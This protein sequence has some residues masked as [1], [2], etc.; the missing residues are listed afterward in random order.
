MFHSHRIFTA[1]IHLP[2]WRVNPAARK[3]QRASSSTHTSRD[4]FPEFISRSRK[5][6]TM[7]STGVSRRSFLKAT[8]AATVTGFAAA[9]G[10][11]T[12]ASA[13]PFDLD[14]MKSEHDHLNKGDLN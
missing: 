12:A 1:Q 5:V 9:G 10:L 13:S 8:T 7:S 11:V 3:V 6:M 2:F 4:D 14:D